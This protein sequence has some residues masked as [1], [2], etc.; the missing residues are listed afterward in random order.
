MNRTFRI[1]SQ[2]FF[3]PVS[4][5]QPNC[6][7]IFTIT[8]ALLLSLSLMGILVI[9]WLFVWLFINLVMLEHTLILGFAT[10]FCSVELTLGRM[11]MLTR[12][13]RASTVGEWH[14]G[15]F[16]LGYSF[17][18]THFDLVRR[19]ARKVWR[20]CVL[21]FGHDCYSHPRNCTDLLSNSGLFLSTD[22]KYLFLLQRILVPFDS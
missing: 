12:R 17:S 7:T 22:R 21:V 4:P 2:D 9:I 5:T 1:E 20:E 8:K 15:Y 13:S 14:H 3:H 19:M 6:G 11:S 16:C 18:S 10:G